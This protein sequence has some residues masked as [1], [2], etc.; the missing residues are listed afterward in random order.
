[1]NSLLV[2]KKV[3][4]VYYS[5]YV[6]SATFSAKRLLKSYSDLSTILNEFKST[7]SILFRKY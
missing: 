5:D 1:M 7:I 4:T 6:L 3:L 2:S